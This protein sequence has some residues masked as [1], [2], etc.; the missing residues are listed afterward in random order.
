MRLIASRVRPSPVTVIS[1]PLLSARSMCDG[2]HG[3]FVHVDQ[4]LA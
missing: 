4:V 3:H 1:T 2:P